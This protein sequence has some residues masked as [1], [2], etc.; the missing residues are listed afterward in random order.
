VAPSAVV[1]AAARRDRVVAGVRARELAA[2]RRRHD[3]LRV[4]SPVHD[5]RDGDCLSTPAAPRHVRA[6]ARRFHDP[7][8]R[9]GLD[10]AEICHPAVYVDA[11][12]QQQLEAFAAR[13]SVAAIGSS[14]FHGLGPM[15]LCRT[16]VFAT[17][18]TEQ[19]VL[20]AVRAHRTV[21]FG[22]GGGVYGDPQL[23]QYAD[24]LRTRL[25]ASHS[26]GTA[27]DWVSRSTG[28]AGFAGLLFL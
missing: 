19:G 22:P 11:S 25:P 13:A 10:G 1:G 4:R 26:H 24:K 6:G 3:C 28:L 7:A 9:R 8:I 12:W 20:E 2:R 18:A 5:R 27:L 14:D 23:T 15:G 21:V 17:E 16:F